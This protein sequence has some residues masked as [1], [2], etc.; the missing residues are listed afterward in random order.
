MINE[1][2]MWWAEKTGILDKWQNG[3]RRGRSCLDN[4]VRVRM[5]A[6]LTARTDER[7]VVAFLDVNAAYDSVIR[8]VL[9]KKFM[10]V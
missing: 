1:R 5:E 4:L 7:M 9:V 10:E 8:D 6:E 2:M 3:F